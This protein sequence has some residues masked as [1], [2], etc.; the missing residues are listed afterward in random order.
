MD[1]TTH[2][3]LVVIGYHGDMTVLANLNP[4]AVEC[5]KQTEITIRRGTL[6]KIIKKKNNKQGEVGKWL[7]AVKGVC[8]LGMLAL[9]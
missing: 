7:C 1:S 2:A 3:S 9:G 6:N 4:T 8:I 5:S